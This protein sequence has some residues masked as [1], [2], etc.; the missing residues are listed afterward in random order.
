VVKLV[1]AGHSV[2]VWN[3]NPAASLR[4]A[5]SLDCGLVTVAETAQQAVAAT[6]IVISTLADGTATCEVLLGDRGA[7]TLMK[8]GTI[9]CD[10]CTGGVDSARMLD[11][12]LSA[13][14]MRFVDAPVSGSVPTIE[15]GQLLVMAS[16]NVAGVDELRPVLGAFAKR[17]SYLG[18]AGAGQSM[19][20]AVNLVVYA[21]NAALSEALA[22]TDDAGIGI[23]DA[24]DVFEDSVVAAPYVAYKRAAFL[25]PHAPVAMSMDL[26]LKDL[27]LIGSAAKSLSI[28]LLAAEA[29]RDEVAAACSAGFGNQDMSALARFLRSDG[30]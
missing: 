18:P 30:G 9:V 2:T 16:G 11:A 22:L 26:A 1:E 7:L 10:M 23:A 14:H 28:D 12:E 27:R 17:V 21:L 19:K 5:E 6:P 24:Y 4:V 3:R 8:P 29:V 25:D 13:R 15:S 20:L